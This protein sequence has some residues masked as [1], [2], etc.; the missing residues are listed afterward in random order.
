MALK[1]WYEQPTIEMLTLL[2]QTYL[3]SSAPNMHFIIAVV[4]NI[5]EIEHKKPL[6]M[7]FKKDSYE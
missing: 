3:N 5:L 1:I 4:M 2:G 6:N 7:Q